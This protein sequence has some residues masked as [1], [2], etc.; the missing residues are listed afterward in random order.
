MVYRYINRRT[1]IFFFSLL[2]IIEVSAYTKEGFKT[3][4]DKSESLVIIRDNVLL[5]RHKTICCDPHLN[6]LSETVQMKGSQH[7]ITFS[8]ILTSIVSVSEHFLLVFFGV[9]LIP[10]FL[11]T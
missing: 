10:C 7:M 5:I 11:S 3:A 8:R 2:L 1:K 9:F 4:L 6:R